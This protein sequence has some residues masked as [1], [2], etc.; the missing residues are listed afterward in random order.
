MTQQ[1]QPTSTPYFLVF[2]VGQAACKRPPITKLVSTVSDVK[3]KADP[4]TR[5]CGGRGNQTYL[6]ELQI[7]HSV[8]VIKPS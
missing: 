8:Y 7:L 5:A 2:D 3:D 1:V 4:P 6:I